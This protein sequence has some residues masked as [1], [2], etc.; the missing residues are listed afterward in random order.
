MNPGKS[1]FLVFDPFG[2]RDD[3]GKYRITG[4]PQVCRLA[5]RAIRAGSNL[6]LCIDGGGLDLDARRE[7]LAC[8]RTPSNR[9]AGGRITELSA[10][11]A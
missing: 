6:G 10:T 9:F 4:P 8:R 1:L 11:D 5:V 2:W 3:V 7:L